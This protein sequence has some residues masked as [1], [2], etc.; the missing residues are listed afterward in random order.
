[1][2]DRSTYRKYQLPS[3]KRLW[4]VVMTVCFFLS[5]AVATPAIESHYRITER[6]P[7]NQVDHYPVKQTP[8]P[9][10]YR[11]TGNWVGRLI[12]P[13]IAEIQNADWVWLEL[14]NAPDKALIG[15][16]IRLEWLPTNAVQQYV[17]AVT[18]D[19]K[20]GSAVAESQEKGNLHPERLNGRSQVGPLQSLAGARS[21]DDVVVTIDQAA[22][23]KENG[24]V[25]LQIESDP[26]IETGRFYGLVKLLAPAPATNPAFI[27]QDCPGP[28][29]CQS[30]LFQVQHYDRNTAKF[31]GA[32]ET[33]RIPQQPRDG[34][35]VFASTP[36][37][38]HK[39]PAGN[40][41]WYIYGAQDRTG[42]FTVQALKPRSL[43]QLQPQRTI[44]D[45]AQ[46]L[47]YINFKQWQGTEQ[48]RG[49]WH[50]L[51][52]A[53]QDK[54]EPPPDWQLGQQAVVMHLFGG[55]G[56][57]S[58]ETPAFGT[59]TGHFSYGLATVVRE[60]LADELQWDIRYQQVYASNMEGIIAGTNTWTAYMG[61][62]RRGWM[63]TRPVADV[64]VNFDLIED[65]DFGGDRISPL[66]E[67]RRQLQVIDARYRTGDGNGAA[68]VT[69]ATS[70]VQ[71]SNQALFATVQ[72]FRQTV[73]QTPTIQTWLA[74]HPED[75]TTLRFRRLIQFGDELEKQ[76]MPLGIVRE[77][78]QSNSDALSGT[79]IRPRTFRRASYGFTKNL[80]AALTSWRTILPRQ[81]Q[82]ELSLLFLNKGAKLWVLQTNQIGGDNP[83]IFPIAPTQAFGRWAI[84]GTPIAL[85]AIILA[86]LLGAI[87]IPHWIDWLIGVASLGIYAA[88]AI[89]WGFRQGFLQWQLWPMTRSQDWKMGA[90]LFF[91]PA[92]LEELVFR[93]LLLPAPFA[94]TWLGGLGWSGASLVL[95]VLYHP[96][97]AL[98][99]HK[100]GNPTFFDRR[101]LTLA[102][103]LG[104]TCT[105]IY[106]LT[107]SVLLIALIHWL[108]VWIW[109]RNMGGWQRVGIKAVD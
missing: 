68:V 91:M 41:G 22:V 52:I 18:R 6:S 26:M 20:F 28:K 25:R 81:T 61:D 51:L 50:T 15:Q 66:Q 85:G 49:Q 79:E 103:L 60:P 46:A 47:D 3:A 29:P 58:G 94:A 8:A 69:P 87:N 9:E 100:A 62:L 43:F 75:P 64:L 21:N 17:T 13:S 99:F 109:L 11:P 72:Q 77:D 80:L 39:S 63:G 37:D 107:C 93:V 1:M 24:K 36:R 89:P 55:R 53:P 76:L 67:F 30:E 101:F 16:R 96:L 5:W 40:A 4:A 2:S 45:R 65:Y 7:F 98:T 35:G 14:Y 19:L 33:I 83:D 73:A 102:T 105:I 88:I 108:V 12:L 104:V 34:I 31:D 32:T 106:W 59:V 74:N 70:C 95:F 27:P 71:D 78:W 56:G 92:L 42:L 57:Q 44:V 38:L 97:N 48:Q 23:V 82:D 54:P 84:P 10:R 86:R 90:K